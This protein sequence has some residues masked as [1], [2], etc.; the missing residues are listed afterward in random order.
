[1]RLLVA[2]TNPNK[3]REIRGIL[4]DI[5]VELVGLEAYPTVAEPV[6]TGLGC[7]DLSGR[8]FRPPEG[9]SPFVPNR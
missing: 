7:G 3:V 9:R 6:E 8:L 1:M 5:D 2:T 4:T